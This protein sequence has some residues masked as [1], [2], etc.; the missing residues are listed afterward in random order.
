VRRDVRDRFSIRNHSRTEHGHNRL[1]SQGTHVPTLL[2]A[3]QFNCS[4][5]RLLD[6][7]CRNE[8]NGLT[9]R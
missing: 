6:R 7:F 4:L 5:L 1:L 8:R 9:A 2:A 3:K